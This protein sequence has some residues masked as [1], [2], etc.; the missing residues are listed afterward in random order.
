MRYH[1]LLARIA[2]IKKTGS[3]KSQQHDGAT[4]TLQY[5]A[6]GNEVMVYPNQENCDP[7]GGKSEMSSSVD[8]ERGEE[9]FLDEK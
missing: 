8:R 1:Y 4:P 9:R 2:E 7:L 3:A 5:C 6:D